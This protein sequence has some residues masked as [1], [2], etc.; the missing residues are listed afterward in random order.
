MSTSP[1]TRASRYAD[2]AVRP[3]LDP[4]YYHL[5]PDELTFFQHL[6][7]IRDEQELRQHIL[8]VQAKAYEVGLRLADRLVVLTC[9]SSMDILVFGGSASSSR[10]Y[11]S[12][13]LV[14]V[15]F[16]SSID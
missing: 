7:G 15:D 9:C 1:P 5:K 14:K 3:K 12:D 2:P 13:A 6:T 8:D 16:F 11:N 4:K 10:F